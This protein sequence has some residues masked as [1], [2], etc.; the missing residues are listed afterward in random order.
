MRRVLAGLLPVLV[1]VG[2][3]TGPVVAASTTF[4]IDLRAEAAAPGATGH[5]K[6]VL[7]PKDGTVCYSI[8]WKGVPAPITGGHIHDLATGGIVISLFGAPHETATSFPGDKFKV[9]GCVEATEA[10]IAAVLAD[11]SAY[12]VNLHIGETLTSVLRGTLA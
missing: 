3:L 8:K 1:A 9:S 2:F 5:A 7:D 10:I 11:P 12:Y 6:I 4:N